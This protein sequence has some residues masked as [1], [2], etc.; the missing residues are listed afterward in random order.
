MRQQIDAALSAARKNPEDAAASGRLGM[1][2]NACEQIE[3]AEQCYRRAHLL[4]S[5]AFAWP[6]YLSVLELRRGETAEAIEDARAAVSIDPNQSA[7]LRLAEA[8]VHSHQ[9]SE[10]RKLYETLIQEDP[11]VAIYHYGLGTVLDAQGGS[12]LEAIEQYKR[13]CELLPQYGD[14]HKALAEDYKA[15]RDSA[16]SASEFALYQQNSSG[17]PPED[18]YMAQITALNP[19]GIILIQGAQQDLAQGQPAEAA[20]QLEAAVAANPNDEGYRSN[21]VLVYWKLK[22]WDKAEEQYRAAIRLNPSTKAHYVFGLVMMEQNRYTEAGAAFRGAL[23]INPRDIGA[24]IQLGRVLELQGDIPGAI[25]QYQAALAIDPNSRAAHYVLGMAHMR[26]LQNQEG[27]DQ[28]LKTLV[29]VD[30]RTPG[31]ERQV[32]AAYRKA[33]D[34]TRAQ[35]YDQLAGPK[36]G[37]EISAAVLAGQTDLST[38]PATDSSPVQ[39]TAPRAN[40]DSPAPREQSYSH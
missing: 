25:Q 19:G 31:Y 39:S 34:E 30:A 20:K 22:R 28:L 27:I 24:N 15:I 14:A 1:V 7:R 5:K 32:A 18:S 12:V 33:G 9:F 38:S 6:Y 29:P 21:L 37:T 10:S 26:Q 13:A 2:L 4:D 40:Q 3:A 35:Y 36:Q 11:R 17:G 16:A 23:A 8:L